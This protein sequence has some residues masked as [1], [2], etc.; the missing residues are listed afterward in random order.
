MGYQIKHPMA[1]Q[2]RLLLMMGFCG[3]LSTF[4]TFSAE[5]MT[6][7]KSGNH[8]LS[9]VYIGASLVAGLIAIYFG[10]KLLSGFE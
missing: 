6:L 5:I 1:Q 4:S 10:I 9:L 8:L 7:L 2:Y 3:G